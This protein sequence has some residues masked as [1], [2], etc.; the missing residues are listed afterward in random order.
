[1]ASKHT[2]PPVVRVKGRFQVTLPPRVRRELALSVGD[3][4]EAEVKDGKITLTPKSLVEREIG[5][6]LKDF[7]QGR[8]TG[9]FNTAEQAIRALRRGKR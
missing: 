3:L 8:F 6:G 1:M 2:A 5:L 9:P 7:E 4:L